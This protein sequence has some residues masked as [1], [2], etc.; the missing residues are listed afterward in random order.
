M[1]NSVF[2]FPKKK[3]SPPRA[4]VTKWKILS[5]SV[6]PIQCSPEQVH[7]RSD[8]RV[9]QPLVRALADETA[10]VRTGHTLR[11]AEPQ[12]AARIGYDSFD[13][14]CR[15]AVGGGVNADR[16]QLASQGESV[17]DDQDCQPAHAASV[18]EGV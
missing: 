9:G 18:I 4:I 5:P 1:A 14:A 16:Q 3:V 7:P 13:A 8:P 2:L 12:E 11:G 6:G 15:A 17:Q 10:E